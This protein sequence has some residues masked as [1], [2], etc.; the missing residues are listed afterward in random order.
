MIL[1]RPYSGKDFAG[2]KALHEKR[3]TPYELPKLD[4][5]MLLGAV[6]EEGGEISNAVFL[7]KTTELYWMF[8]PAS[9]KRERIGRLQIFQREMI[10]AA[11]RLGITDVHGWIPA[12]AASERF[13][14]MLR[15]RFGWTR[16]LWDCYRLEVG[17]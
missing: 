4:S 7:R 12:E 3:H 6:M 1:I 8:D 13:D 5:D 15:N 17:K 16:P 2:V 10:P 9:R 11:R 14:A